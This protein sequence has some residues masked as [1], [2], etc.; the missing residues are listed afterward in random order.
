[1]EDSKYKS[2]GKRINDPVYQYA[3]G[4]HCKLCPFPGY[5]CDGRPTLLNQESLNSSFPKIFTEKK[6]GIFS[7]EEIIMEI[8][9]EAHV[10]VSKSNQNL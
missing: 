8:K 10:D 3:C 4:R 5:K 7:R 6:L 1:M 9:K 2:V